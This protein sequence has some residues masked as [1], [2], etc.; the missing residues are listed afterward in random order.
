MRAIVTASSIALALFGAIT[1][2]QTIN[3]DRA[4]AQTQTRIYLA[5]PLGFSEAGNQFK[6]MLVD[7]LKQ[8]GY[9]VVDPFRLTPKQKFDEI[10]KMKTLDEK[11]EAWQKLNPEIGRTNQRA[12]DSCNAVL[13]ILDGQDVD[14]GTA[15][16]IGYAFARGKPI[17]GYRNDLRLAADN[18]GATV[19]L[20]VEYFITASG[21]KIVNT[22]AA[23]PDALA[24]V[25]NRKP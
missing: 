23:I 25:L 14:S 7:K 20:Q 19:N 22:A 6:D 24:Q 3:S 15:A 21:G 16:E 2:A 11:H 18:I 5:G 8:T 12:I 4:I 13:A 9:E 17:L 1:L 10:D